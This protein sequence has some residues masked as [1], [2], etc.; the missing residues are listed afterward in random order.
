MDI[1][2][3][4]NNGIDATSLS[5][6]R[7]YVTWDAS[8]RGERC[9]EQSNAH[10]PDKPSASSVI[11]IRSKTEQKFTIRHFLSDA[12]ARGYVDHPVCET[13]L[14]AWSTSEGSA[15]M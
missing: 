8:D 13:V 14:Q 7:T 11:S 1:T 4:C 9:S 12:A 3:C 5:S 6:P 10:L 2:L 15:V